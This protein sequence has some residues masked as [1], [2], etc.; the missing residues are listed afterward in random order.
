MSTLAPVRNLSLY[1]PDHPS[2]PRWALIR[3]WLPTFVWLGVIAMES[4]SIFTSDHT[5]SWVY[6]M[7]KWMG[8]RLAAYSW[9]I[10]AA[11]RKFGH[12]TGYA[13]LSFLAF[14][15]WTEFLAYWKELRFAKAGKTIHVP[16]RWHLRAAVLSVLVTLVAASLD[17]FHQAFIPGRTGVFHDVVLD[18]LGGVFA[19]ILLLFW[20]LRK[21]Q[22]RPAP[23]FETVSSQ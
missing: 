14:Y 19:Q 1:S 2:S 8:P 18:T 20:S 9:L 4:T 16:R 21:I 22:P 13:I 10:N 12:F 11:G 7:L 17:E 15:G 5:Q 3:A 6:G 23:D